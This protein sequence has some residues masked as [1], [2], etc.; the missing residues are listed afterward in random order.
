MLNV[1]AGV[2]VADVT[3]G[4]PM[5]EVPAEFDPED[6]GPGPDT[7]FEPEPI[8]KEPEEEIAE[9]NPPPPPEGSAVI[10][11]STVTVKVE[12]TVTVMVELVIMVVGPLKMIVLP[13]PKISI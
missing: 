1:L 7:E 11:G 4:V 8:G 6:A 5:P 13:L 10:D 3:G 9:V 2:A 12:E